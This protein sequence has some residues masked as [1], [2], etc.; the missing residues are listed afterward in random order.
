[1]KTI[2]LVE[3]IEGE[4]KLACSWENNVIKDARIEFLN[5][6]GFELILE[7]K[8]PL[9]AL[10]YTP[11]ICGICGQAHLHATVN[12]LENIYKNIGEELTITKKAKLLREIGLN[13]E[14][15]DSHIKWFYMFIMPDIVKLSKDD[16]SLYEPLKGEK[17][18]K[19][20]SVASETIKSLAIIGGQWPHTSYM[21]PGGVVS[22]PTLLDLTSMQNYLDQA[23]RF[24][25]ND[26]VG[27]NF[28]T[29]LSSSGLKDINKI[30]GDLKDFINLS[31]EHNLEK[32]GMSYDKHIVLGKSTLFKSGRINKRL[33]TKIDLNRISENTNFTYNVDEKLDTK[34]AYGWAKN[35][36]Y[37][38][39]FY[40]TGPLSRAL[41]Q[42][43][44][45]IK[46]I[47]KE[48][49][50]SVFTRVMARI[51]EL[52]RLLYMTKELIKQVDISEES[53][54]KPGI[55]L[56]EIDEAK[57]VGV[58]EACRGSLF[59]EVSIKEGKIETYNVI[60]PT[61]WNL[62]PG[63]KDNYSIAQKAIIG[64]DSIEKAKIILRSFDVCS[65]CTTH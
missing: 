19:A 5:F 20:S 55:S 49:K 33:S 8:A 26:V 35:A 16:Y 43:R 23:V 9:D 54:I 3:R 64:N 18:L 45:F 2:D 47:H 12:A 13:I 60:T 59:H 7:G 48:Y 29:Y 36:M 44:K 62:G 31:F 6:R 51:D 56:S 41:I 22:D 50:D 24:F 32:T 14:I 57:A 39:E 40:E 65:V 46:E 1:M 34:D 25:E 61:V 27:M 30:N 42:S 37:S 17:W 38:N 10:I 58:V 21:I 28:E 53:F 15:I 52:S 63:N 4:A 11:R